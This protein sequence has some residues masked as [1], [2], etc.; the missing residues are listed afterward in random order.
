MFTGLIEEVGIV[1]AL[2]VQKGNSRLT[3][4][5]KLVTEDLHLGD[6]IDLNG[7]CLTVPILASEHSSWR[8]PHILPDRA[9]FITGK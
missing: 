3:I 4:E 1:K 6:S 7:V 5:A 9:L 2:Q 8:R